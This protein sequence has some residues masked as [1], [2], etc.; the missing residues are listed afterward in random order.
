MVASHIL[1]IRRLEMHP[2]EG[3]DH[4]FQWEGQP[5]SSRTLFHLPSAIAFGVLVTKV[6]EVS[7]L[8]WTVLLSS[9]LSLQTLRFSVAQA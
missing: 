7:R 5:T 3:R 9:L 8:Q 6:D 2:Y 1:G 4:D